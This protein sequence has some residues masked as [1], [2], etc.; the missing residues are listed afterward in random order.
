MMQKRNIKIDKDTTIYTI[1]GL[2][3]DTTLQEISLTV[4][5]KF[6]LQS[7]PVFCENTK[8][9]EPSKDQLIREEISRICASTET[10]IDSDFFQPGT[11]QRMDKQAYLNKLKALLGGTTV[12]DEQK[13]SI[14]NDMLCNTQNQSSDL[15]KKSFHDSNRCVRRRENYKF[16]IRQL[17]QNI[18]DNEKTYDD[19]KRNRIILVQSIQQEQER[20]YLLQS[21]LNR[22]VTSIQPYSTTNIL[23]GSRQEMKTEDLKIK[24]EQEIHQKM[25]TISSLKGDVVFNDK[26]VM[27]IERIINMN[28]IHLNNR[29]SSFN[30][31]QKQTLS[32]SETKI[33]KSTNEILDI[34]MSSWL[35]WTIYLKQQ[36]DAVTRI[37]SIVIKYILREV[38]GIWFRNITQKPLIASEVNQSQLFCKGSKMLAKA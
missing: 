30:A 12:H 25:V 11:L 8:T 18:E 13:L 1:S 32:T 20:I 22:L 33:F 26:E 37:F 23:N 15:L 38:M 2:H 27:R 19:L 35:Q 21:E 29:L 3:G 4:T 36:R 6:G 17:E 7:K 16:R 10:E 9:I 31:F 5:N 14:D 28:K 34:V 24:V